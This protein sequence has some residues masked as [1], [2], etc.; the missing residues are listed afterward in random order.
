[1][2]SPRKQREMISLDDAPKRPRNPFE[3][4][5]TQFDDSDL[6]YHLSVRV[7]EFFIRPPC[8]IVLITISLGR[9]ARRVKSSS[10]E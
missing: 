4:G 5:L 7:L 6:D 10:I 8:P 2:K 1:M 3:R 9:K